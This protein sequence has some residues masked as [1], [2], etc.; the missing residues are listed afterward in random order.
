[1]NHEIAYIL[2]RFFGLLLVA[3]GLMVLARKDQKTYFDKLFESEDV[4]FVTGLMTMT[5]GA[6][7]VALINTW[8]FDWIGL[9]TLLGWLTLIK[10]ATILIA[11]G[12][13]MEIW[14]R[15][16]VYPWV[17][18]S[19]GVISLVLGAYLIWVGFGL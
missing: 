15:T 3:I 6:L 19:S 5:I 4:L 8:T 7:A 9:V 17:L 12:K 14:K 13:S 18:V 10:G 1:M 11:P 2:A 16:S